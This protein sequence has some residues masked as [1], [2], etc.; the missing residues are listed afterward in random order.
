MTQQYDNKGKSALW[1]NDKNG[2][3]KAPDLKGHIYA[4]R[5]IAAGEMIELALWRNISDNPKAP[6]LRGMV[7]DKRERQAN[8][9]DDG[10]VEDVPFRPAN[11]LADDSIP[12]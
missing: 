2:N 7:S 4:H 1:S 6:S 9:L 10:S 11:S 8:S 3:E 5:D 12:F